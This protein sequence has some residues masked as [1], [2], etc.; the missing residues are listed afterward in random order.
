MGCFGNVGVTF[1]NVN[2]WVVIIT[3]WFT[4]TSERDLVPLKV[5]HK[6]MNGFVRAD[7][8]VLSSL[9]IELFNSVVIKNYFRDLEKL[10][11]RVEN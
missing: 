11:L 3:R 6:S 9:V 8:S 5:L 10:Q 1:W 7:C 4:L 2:E